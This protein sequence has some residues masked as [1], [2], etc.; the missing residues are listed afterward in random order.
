MPDTFIMSF[1]LATSFHSCVGISCRSMIKDAFQMFL[2]DILD[3][4]IKHIFVYDIFVG[5]LES[6]V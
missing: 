4:V 6:L 3:Y 1:F 2:N 5:T